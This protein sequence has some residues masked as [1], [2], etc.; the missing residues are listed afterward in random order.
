MHNFNRFYL[1]GSVLFSFL[2]PLFIIYT[3]TS[4]GIIDNVQ[5]V[6]KDI[7]II[8]T[9]EI[10]ETPINYWTYFIY[11]SIFISGILLIRFIRNIL[12]IYQKTRGN[13][14]VKHKKATL[15][16][17]DD[18]I[19]PHTF[20]NYIFIN[21]DE[22]Y[23][24]KIEEELFTHELTHATQ[25]HTFDVLLVEVLKIIFWFNPIFYFLKKTIQLNHEFLADTKVISNHKNISEYQYLLLN[26]TAWN[27]EYYLASNLNYLLTKKRLLMMTKQ[28]SRTKI[29]FKKLA[30]IPVIAGFIFLFA[31]RVE[32][33][34]PDT[35]LDFFTVKEVNKIPI[36]KIDSET[37]KYYFN[38]RLIELKD[39]KK[40]FLK[41]TG[42]K[43]SNLKIDN[44]GKILFSFI[45]S[46]QKELSKEYLNEIL[47]I[48]NESYIYDDGMDLK[49]STIKYYSPKDKDSLPNDYRTSIKIINLKKG[50]ITYTAKN[51]KV[52]TKKISELTN[53][54][55]KMIPPPPPLRSKTPVL[56][57]PPPKTGF[58]ESNGDKLYYIQKGKSFTFYN[59]H[60]QIVTKEGKIINSEQTKSTNVIPGQN[61][62]K[63]YKNSKVVAE[64]KRNNIPPS[65]PKANF[66]EVKKGDISNIRPPTLKVKKGTVS[67]I[68]P[69]PPPM[70]A[71]ELL[72]RYPD[73][74]FYFNNK[75]ASHK[76]VSKLV[77]NKKGLSVLTQDIDNKKTIKFTTKDYI[78]KSW[79]SVDK[80]GKAISTHPNTKIIGGNST[81]KDN[82]KKGWEID[83]K[84]HVVNTSNNLNEKLNILDIINHDKTLNNYPI[85][86]YF[87][88]KK[89]ITEKFLQRINYLNLETTSLKKINEKEINIYITTKK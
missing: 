58:H 10:I 69:P 57:P 49:T 8:E 31:E 18:A 2:A 84:V 40:E 37:N 44:K 70:S 6:A 86:R 39:L 73:A 36:L 22:Y 23:S 14:T 32:A 30:V 12:S 88:N 16:L 80:N 52:I 1:L 60:G 53:E 9:T 41:A 26:K 19:S 28:S 35:N 5:S 71:E 66:P 85:K 59:K 83:N 27:N 62:T 79:I 42:N 78:E 17:V 33:K 81:T 61:V 20:W 21:K 4:V 11:L 65:P 51:G 34:I 56:I 72:F 7:F 55:K 67:D 89:K 15:I 45:K 38:N 43:K 77:K 64:F 13:E 63:V 50:I 74:T 24:Q 68:P 29:L 47:L 3:K 76:K 46:I 54:E 75:R 82:V 25:K 87:L 48:N